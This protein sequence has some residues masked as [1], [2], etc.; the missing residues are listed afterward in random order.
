M[1]FENKDDCEAFFHRLVES[2]WQLRVAG[3]CLG[4]DE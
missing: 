1:V 3:A 2:L 4:V